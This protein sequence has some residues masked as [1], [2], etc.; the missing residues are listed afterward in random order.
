MNKNFYYDLEP[1]RTRLEREYE[2]NDV[3]ISIVTP[4]YNSSELIFQT[5]NC[6]LNQT[7]PYYEWLV[8]D[9]GSTSKESLEVLEKLESTDSR[10]K[11][12][13]KKNEGP[14]RHVTME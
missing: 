2:G 1:G 9:D 3:V 12:L 8:V 14:A 10:I 11:V 5:M 4:T 13:H 7:Y 6:I